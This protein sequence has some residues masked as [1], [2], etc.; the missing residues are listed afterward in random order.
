MD[1]EYPILIAEIG[2]CH[3]GS[4]DRA[5]KL[6]KL[7]AENGADIIKFQKRNPILSTPAD[8]AD[9][10]H[11]MPYFS[12][13]KTYLEH[14]L[15]LELDI[16]CHIE[17]KKYC[18]SLNCKYSSSVWDMDSAKEICSINPC[19]IKI[20]SACNMHYKM[21][22]YCIEKSEAD[23]HI[24]LGMLSLEDKKKVI[25]RYKSY[26]IIFYHT[27]SEYPC[28]FENLFLL[29]IKKLLDM[30]LRVGFSNHGYG[31]AADI[32]AFTLGAKYIERHFIDDRAFRHTDAAASLEPAGLKTLKRDLLNVHKALTY[33]YDHVTEQESLQASKLR[34]TEK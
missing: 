3:I 8:I 20:P 23:V 34:N 22:D 11:P 10:P 2:A 6:I 1:E 26:K 9:K 14:R 33:K 16:E 24:S 29:E 18:E 17:L 4:F 28:P 13:G 32:S 25:D 31:I 30:G 15:N 19:F 5:K 27:T 12:Y 7:A 21:I